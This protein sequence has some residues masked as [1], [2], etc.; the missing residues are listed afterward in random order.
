MAVPIDV[1]RCYDDEIVW[2]AETM[3]KCVTTETDAFYGRF[4][5]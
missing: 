2:I 5:C 3:K 1:I 4:R